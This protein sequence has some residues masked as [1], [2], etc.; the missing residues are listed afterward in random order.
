MLKGI[1]RIK[2]EKLGF[3]GYHSNRSS[4]WA[5]TESMG[6]FL[7]QNLYNFENT[8]PKQVPALFNVI[9]PTARILWDFDS[10][11]GRIFK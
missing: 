7:K 3:R 4:L 5:N 1:E 10:W 11:R 9:N 8:Y 6:N 2:Y